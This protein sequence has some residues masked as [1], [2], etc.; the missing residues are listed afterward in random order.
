[1]FSF[2]DP[3]LLAGKCY[4]ILYFLLQEK[5]RLEL[6]FLA[7][8]HNDGGGMPAKI[9]TPTRNKVYPRLLPGWVD[10]STRMGERNHPS[11]H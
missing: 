6:T 9:S 3:K 5:Q 2:L 8:R 1:M 7:W 10:K 11:L 4:T